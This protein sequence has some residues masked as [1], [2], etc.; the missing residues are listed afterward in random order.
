VATVAVLSASVCGD[1][2]SVYIVLFRTQSTTDLVVTMGVFSLMLA[3]WCAG[4]LLIASHKR[5][6]PVL[7]HVA[8]WLVPSV[9]LTIGVVILVRTGELLEL[10]EL[11]V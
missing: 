5:A 8:G 4:A 6:V 11:A 3:V 1:N 9:L 2:L 7:S 10:V